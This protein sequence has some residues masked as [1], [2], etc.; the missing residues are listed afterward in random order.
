MNF[1]KSSRD[2]ISVLPNFQISKS[3]SVFEICIPIWKRLFAGGP[4]AN[5]KLFAGGPPAN[6][7]LFAGGPPVNKTS[8]ARALSIL[9]SHEWSCTA[10][11]ILYGIIQSLKYYTD[12]LWYFSL[13]F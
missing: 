7:K 5:K 12:V 3:H 1:C 10:L 8:F 13:W 9:Y 4:L 6:K 2:K 11:F